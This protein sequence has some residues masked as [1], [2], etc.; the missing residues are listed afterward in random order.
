MKVAIVTDTHFGARSDDTAFADYFEKFYSETFFPYL[1]KNNIST[2]IHTGD[3]V[4]RRKYIN[5]LTSF[6]MK[7]MFFTP[8][9]EANIDII[10]AVGNHDCFY[11]NTNMINSMSE[12]FGNTD[13]NIRVY[14]QATEIELQGTKI[15]LV[16]WICAENHDHAIKMI[17][18]TKAQ[19]L[20][21]H[22]EVIGFEM[23]PGY[24]NDEGFDVK[25]FSKFEF[26]G[27][28]H[29]HHR[30]SNGNVHY[31]GCPYEMTW[32][33]H[34][35]P[36]GFHVFDTS[37]RELQFI[38]NPNR[39]F[40][41]IFYDDSVKENY[42]MNS[43]NQKICKVVVVQKNDPYKFDQFMDR[44]IKAG[45]YDISVVEDHL[46]LSTQDSTTIMEQAED[47]LTIVNRYIS[48][49]KLEELDKKA[50]TKLFFQLYNEALTSD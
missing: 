16:P 40:N 35:D 39:M 3:V 48:G 22:L 6:R 49:M 26:V 25:Y 41:K 44:L 21:G 8:A 12:F 38:E 29:L 11:N 43:F 23:Y 5:Y 32:N 17:E 27:S 14:D 4:D 37:T 45:P 36:K 15:L 2:I 46:N 19:I 30:S 34:G 9:K 50:V 33:D 42:D 18:Q 7:K 47:T 24:V 31:F 28:G 10:I 13:S 20:L 1:I